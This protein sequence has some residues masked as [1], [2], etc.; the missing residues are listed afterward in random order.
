VFVGLHAAPQIA[1]GPSEFIPERDCREQAKA[2]AVASFL[3][4]HG[5]RRRG[6]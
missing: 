6:R 3:A 4:W 5:R 2:I 1:E